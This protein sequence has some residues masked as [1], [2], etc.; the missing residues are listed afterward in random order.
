MLRPNKQFRS[1]MSESNWECGRSMRYIDRASGMYDETVP[2]IRHCASMNSAQNTRYN[3]IDRCCVLTRHT[4]HDSTSAIVC[5]PFCKC[6]ADAH[7]QFNNS[8][9]KWRKLHLH[10]HTTWHRMHYITF[11]CSL[12]L[13]KA[14]DKLNLY[15]ESQIKMFI[16]SFQRLL[17][18]AFTNLLHSDKMP[19]GCVWFACWISAIRCAAECVLWHRNTRDIYHGKVY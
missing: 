6:Y 3:R 10:H 14:N 16:G 12:Q 5:H 15:W 2:A 1:T 4:T 13:Q 11:E 7:I 9:L 17:R 8:E 18:L 19:S